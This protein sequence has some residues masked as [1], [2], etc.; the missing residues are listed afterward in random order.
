M[1]QTISEFE[2]IKKANN[3]DLIDDTFSEIFASKQAFQSLTKHFLVTTL[4][5]KMA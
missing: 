1:P 4:S 3:Y 5:P 2:I